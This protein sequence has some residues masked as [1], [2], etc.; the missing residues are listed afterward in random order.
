V[1]CDA[2]VI[3]ELVR[4]IKNGRAKSPFFKFVFLTSSHFGYEYPENHNI[5]HPTA[6]EGSFIFNKY[7]D[8]GPLLNKYKNSLHYNDSLFG[9]V[10]SALKEKQLDKKTIIVITSDHGEEFNDKGHGNWG[11]GSNFSRYQ[12]S[13]PL[14]MYLCDNEKGHVIHKRSSHIDISPTLLKHVFGCSNPLS[15]YSSGSDLL[16]LPDNRGLIVR[17]YNTKAYI[18]DDIVYFQGITLDSYDIDDI[19]K[20]NMKFDYKKI[21]QLKMSETSFLQFRQ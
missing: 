16:N 21:E 5:F 9:E 4:S 11:H 13:V 7:A 2:Y 8:P 15:D 12:T 14:I 3:S 20:K 18:M 1:G 6:K 17:S 10:L 19:I